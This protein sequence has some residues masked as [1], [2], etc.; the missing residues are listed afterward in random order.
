MVA[1]RY[2]FIET[3]VGRALLVA[4]PRGLRALQLVK[5]GREAERVREL[6]EQHPDAVADDGL[7]AKWREPIEAIMRGEKKPNEVE[8]DLV[9][10]PFQIRVWRT[11]CRIP[12]GERRTYAEIA[13]QVG[14]PRAMQAVGQACGANPIG[15]VVPCHRVVRQ[16][17]DLGGYAWG[18]KTKRL[19]LA[20]ERIPAGV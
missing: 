15:L 7:D 9:G 12:F 17:G 18:V 20:R 11:L 1:L 6:L 13:N 4:S 5:P 10:T 16:G 2:G 3:A 19:L 8:L 14:S